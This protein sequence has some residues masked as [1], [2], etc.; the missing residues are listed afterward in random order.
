MPQRSGNSRASSTEWRLKNV[1]PRLTPRLP[2]GLR[3]GCRRFRP[4]MTKG[5]EGPAQLDD[6][7]IPFQIQLRPRIGVRGMNPAA[8][9]HDVQI[10]AGVNRIA[11][12]RVGAKIPRL[13]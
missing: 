12:A 10:G 2:D 1:G 6:R 13:A 11:Q 3:L 7:L 9:P 4:R 8:I 5:S